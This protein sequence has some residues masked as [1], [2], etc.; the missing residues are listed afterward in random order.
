VTLG[1]GVTLPGATSGVTYVFQNGVTIATGATVNVGT[2]AT[3][4]G[5]TFGT[6]QGA[7]I[8]LYGGTLNQLSNSI[9][10]MYAPTAGTYNSIAI[11]Q[12]TSNPTSPLQVQFGSNNQV[13][14]GII[15]APG[16]QVYLQDNGGGV[17]ATGVISDTMFFKSSN[18][19][20]PGYSAANLATTPFRIVTL[21][22]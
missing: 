2:P 17:T 7:T 9:L 8:D 22:E 12:P 3:Y 21:T 6:T 18:L 4:S 10:N 14:D 19:T 5:G 11:M 1:D 20:I 13:L 15:Y 16:T